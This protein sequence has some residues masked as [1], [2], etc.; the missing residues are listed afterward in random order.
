MAEMPNMLDGLCMIAGAEFYVA[1]DGKGNWPRLALLPNGDIAAA[2][3]N[4]PSHGFGCGEIE[5]WM[6]TDGGRKWSLRSQVSDHADEPEKVRMNHAMGLNAQGELVVAVSGWSEGRRLPLI[7]VQVCISGDEGRTWERH[8]LAT[9]DV[10]YGNIICEPD[11]SLICGMYTGAG[12]PAGR[13]SHL[14]ASADHGR[15]WEKRITLARAGSETSLLRCR[16]GKWLAAM[17]KES[18]GLDLFSSTDG[19]HTWGAPR[20]APLPGYPGD[21]VQLDDGK[22]LLVAEPRGDGLHGVA[23]TISEDEGETWKPYMVFVSMPWSGDHGYP[24]SVQLA[25]GTV[26]TAYYFGGRSGEGEHGG[27][28]DLPDNHG[29]PWHRRYHMSI[30]RWRLED[31]GDRMKGW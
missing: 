11:G 2:V 16:S 30:M 24:S 20:A 8:L 3:Y 13:A 26:V 17:R 19:G 14:Y 12:D 10:P 15:K 31:L 23:A 7:P 21:L 9:A 27:R 28:A 22:V 29:L 25:D 18:G 5:L 4:H 6:S 1:I